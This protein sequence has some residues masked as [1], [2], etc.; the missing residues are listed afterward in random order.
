MKKFP[1]SQKTAFLETIP[2]ASLD[3]DNNITAKMK[4][5]F[6]YFDSSQSL[7]FDITKL[8]E[9][10][11]NKLSKKLI[12]YSRESIEHWKNIKIGGGNHRNSIL[13]IYGDF[14]SRS[15]FIHPQNIPHQALWGRFRLESD[16]RLVGFI[17]PNNYHGNIHKK[18]GLAYDK[19]TFYIVF[20]DPNHNFY[21]TKK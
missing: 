15:N 21:P 13:V 1:N 19:N 14:P 20:I 12:E 8:N 7:G 16:L 6:N 10:H 17:I 2:T 11:S 5:N 4:F 3:Q 18:T 9:E